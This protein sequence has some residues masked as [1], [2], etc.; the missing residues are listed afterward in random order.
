MIVQT[1]A[2]AKLALMSV[3]DGE[4]ELVFPHF[5][6]EDQMTESEICVACHGCCMYVTVPLDPPRSKSQKDIFRWYLLHQNVEIYIDHDKQWQILFKTRCKQL[7]DNGMCAIYENR[8]QICKDYKSDSCSRVGKDYIELFRTPAQL[9][10]YFQKK[11]AKS[12]K[13]A[14]KASVKKAAKPATSKQT[15]TAKKSVR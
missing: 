5:E 4:I 15:K 9:E 3:S 6:N 2:P 12:K 11:A 13:S 7:L 1:A 8:P 10:Q 14:A